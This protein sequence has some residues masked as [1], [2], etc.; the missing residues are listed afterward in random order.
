VH[1][2]FP[3]LARYKAVNWT[4]YHHLF[5]QLARS[6]HR[7]TVL[8][9]PPA[10]LVETNFQEIDVELP[11][12]IRLLDVPMPGWLWNRAWPLDKLVKKGAYGR[13]CRSTVARILDQDPPEVLLVYNLPQ[14]PLLGMAPAPGHP[15]LKVFDLADD[16]EAM[17]RTELGALA[18]PPLLAAGRHTLHGM[19]READLVLAVSHTL[20]DAYPG[21]DIQ[22]L[23]N[24]V[25][26]AR[27][28]AR[29]QSA[30]P[31]RPG[32][33]VV[34]YLGAFE[35]FIDFEL[36]LALA[37]RLPDFS[38]RLIGGGRDLPAV[39]EKV[40][41]RGLA[42]VQLPGPLP[43]HEV[44]DALADFDYCLNLFVPIP[45]SHGA[46][47][48]KLF[49]YLAMGKPVLSTDLSE[50]RRLAPDFL[51]TVGDA[52]AG[53]AALRRLEADPAQ[54]ARLARAG[55]DWVE[56]SFDWARLAERLV[57]KIE[58]KLAQAA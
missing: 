36:I 38:F 42:N 3:Y 56:R 31:R 37:S 20:A 4:R 23:P 54:R 17:L 7:V 41:T 9:P 45:I 44:P 40:R 27:F 30:G 11:A 49:E 16:Y 34:G 8:Q 26:L 48:L 33:P 6:G 18:L 52:E 24:G 47:P 58:T 10:T 28:A 22:V 46:C 35:Y 12:G 25:D 32:P 57:E 15:Y 55:L 21:R 5:D 50:L 53:A 43:Y 1:F 29:R 51:V 13:A 39:R 2:L 14:A 19:M